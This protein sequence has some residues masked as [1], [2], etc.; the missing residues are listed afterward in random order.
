MGKMIQTFQPLAE[1]N[2][3]GCV[4]RHQLCCTLCPNDLAYWR[5]SKARFPAKAGICRAFA[6]SRHMVV[7]DAY[8]PRRR[9]SRGHQVAFRWASSP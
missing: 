4:V 7:E 2:R 6:Y 5:L 1:T 8:S 3:D 9:F